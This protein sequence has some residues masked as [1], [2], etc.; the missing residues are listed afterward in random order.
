MTRALMPDPRRPRLG[1]AAVAVGAVLVLLAGFVMPR[2]QIPALETD[3]SSATVARACP[4]MDG[5]AQLAVSTDREGLTTAALT[6]PGKAQVRHS[7]DLID[8]TK[9]PLRMTSQ[10]SAKAWGVVGSAASGLS[11]TPCLQARST[12]Y[13]TG[14]MSNANVKSQLLLTNLDS[15]E[16]NVNVTIFGK[17]GQM[18]AP[19]SRGIVVKGRSQ[20]L[21]ALGPLF[22]SADPATL[23]VVTSSGRVAAVVRTHVFDGITSLGTDWMNGRDEPATSMVIPG[24]GSGDGDRQLIIGNTG[25]RTS[26][27][28]VEVLGKEG[29]YS[30]IGV[31]KVDVPSGSTRAFALQDATKGAAVA[32]R[33]TSSRPV[34]AAVRAKSGNDWASM[35]AASGVGEKAHVTIPVTDGVTATVLA[36]N[37]SDKPVHVV[38]GAKS[39][40]GDDLGTATFDLAPGVSREFSPKF[41]AAIKLEITSSDPG[42]RIAVAES[43]SAGLALLPIEE[44]GTT[45]PELPVKQNPRVGT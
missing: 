25:D 3:V 38:L 10:L 18:P 35:S 11:L 20:T 13:F 2:I 17:D 28:T 19:G 44:S 29:P 5:A 16:A 8:V 4:G 39:A 1:L 42:L 15:S 12:H 36:S 30:P 26:E 32:L 21:V 40:S 22:D 33:V 24:I 7:G 43:S 34:T 27:V 31:E 37:P 14:V 41:A 6:D 23:Q 45:L 9:D